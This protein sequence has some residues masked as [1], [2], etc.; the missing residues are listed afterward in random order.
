M[1]KN[2]VPRLIDPAPYIKAAVDP[3]TG[4]RLLPPSMTLGV[5]SPIKEAFRLALRVRDE[6]DAVMRY[7]WYNLPD[8][9]DGELIE[10]M[11]Y[12]RGQLAFA[13]IK[14]VGRFMMLPYTLCGGKDNASA[15]DEYARY[16]TIKLVSFSGTD[17]VKD[18]PAE[19]AK[20]KSLC[21][22]LSA[23]EFNVRYEV[24]PYALEMKDIEE[25]AVI[26][27]D[28]TSQ[29]SEVNI[30]RR[31]I[32]DPILDVEA[33]C[34][35]YSN[36]AMINSTGV[37]G[38]RVPNEDEKQNVVA[39]NHSMERAALNGEKAIPI[40]GPIEFQELTGGK[41]GTADEFMVMAQAIDNFRLSLYGLENGGLYQKKTYVNDSQ[42]QMNGSNPS[43]VY[44]NGLMIRQKFCDIVNS[45]WGLGIA[46]EA[47]EFDSGVDLNGDGTLDD[48]RD[49]SGSMA[50]EQPAGVYDE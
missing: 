3:K 17:N 49:Q 5:S 39:M 30:P 31:E 32:Q 27:K 41:V 42:T 46:C 48:R 11:L 18:R 45:I 38:M 15:L 7:S 24:M 8:G 2:G 12:Y 9:I 34:F 14:E 4:G 16:D 40:V 26:L 13:Y 43:G 21:T 6:Q 23:L 47:S 35:A 22:I 29:L 37:N 10:R 33:A 44:H 25:S 50:G 28:Y 19:D 1:G 20:R 36:T